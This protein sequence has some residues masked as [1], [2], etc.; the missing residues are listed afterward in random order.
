MGFV[1]KAATPNS[2]NND[3]MMNV[4]ANPTFSIYDLHL[5]GLNTSNT[6]LKPLST[7]LNSD[8]A[9]KYCSKN[10]ISV[11][12]AYNKI[13][14]AWQIFKEVERYESQWAACMAN[15]SSSNI[16]APKSNPNPELRKKL[17]IIP[18]RL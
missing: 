14:K 15:Y 6:S 12:D 17:S 3:F 4:L 11:R 10:N 18:L 16:F 2:S 1:S 9:K 13:S 5:V 7:Y 8:N